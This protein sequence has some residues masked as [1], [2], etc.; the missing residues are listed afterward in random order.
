MANPEDLV[1]VHSF[2]LLC[3]LSCSAVQHGKAEHSCDGRG[4]RLGVE[5]RGDL[6]VWRDGRLGLESAMDELSWP[7]SWATERKTLG[8]VGWGLGD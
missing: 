7:E 8:Y 3:T 1:R 5:M 6:H 4:G 2:R